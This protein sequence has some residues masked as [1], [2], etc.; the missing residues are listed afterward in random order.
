[1]WQGEPHRAASLSTII[2]CLHVAP[3]PEMHLII[4]YYSRSLPVEGRSICNMAS[5]PL[6]FQLSTCRTTCAQQQTNA[7]ASQSMRK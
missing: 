3:E 7:A 4:F 6:T 1:M 2:S 5:V